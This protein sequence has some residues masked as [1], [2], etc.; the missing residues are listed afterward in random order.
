VTSAPLHIAD[1]RKVTIAGAGMSGL[2]LAI[3][4]A[5][6]GFESE[7]WERHADPRADP[8]IAG[9]PN[10][11]P[12]ILALGER[13]RHALRLAG[14]E[15]L[16]SHT[17]TQMRGRMIHDRRGRTTLQPYGVH[18]WEVLYSIRR[19][20]LLR[21]LLDAAEATG[22]VSIRFGQPVLDV[23]WRARTLSLEGVGPRPF[24]V[25]VGADGARSAVR[26]SM[27][28]ATDLEVDEAPLDAGWKRFTI[29]RCAGGEPPLA[30]G[31]LHVWPR[32]GYMM[33]AMPDI[34]G[35]FPAMLFL[36]RSGD[37]S[38]P[39]GFAELDSWTRQQAFMEFNFPDVAPLIPELEREFRD[40]GVGLLGTIRCSRWFVDGPG[41]APGLL[42]GDAAHTI[43]PFH[44]QGVNAAFEDCSALME[45]IDGGAVDWGSAFAHLQNARRDDANAIADM[46][47]DAYRVMRDSV[48][49]RDFMLRKALERELE[50]RHPGL[51]VPRYSLV[52]FHR[53]PYRE[54]CRRG[55]I[56]RELL[57]ELLQ[58]KDQLT[59]VDLQ[60]TARLVGERLTP[61]A[62]AP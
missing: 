7:I 38:M 37:H 24:E 41:Q 39:W 49:H 14:L 44:G 25:L 40:N 36:P 62:I 53:V 33:I 50:R 27:L 48:R 56:Q 4:L 35:S 5:R 12:A 16:V 59:E 43:V 2:L 21:C 29:P 8:R 28:R 32:G 6:R 31:V 15:E 34:D 42:L 3:L 22:K 11:A 23:D 13:G 1:T 30:T 9:E 54:A 51:F 55:R 57:D 60:Q 58:G 17:V 18:P 46:A 19:E 10:A 52:M 45:I 61:V 20:R 47:L 26:R